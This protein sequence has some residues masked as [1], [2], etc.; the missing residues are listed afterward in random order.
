[1]LFLYEIFLVEYFVNIF[2]SHVAPCDQLLALKGG[3][4]V[5]KIPKLAQ[6][7]TFLDPFDLVMTGKLVYFLF[8]Y[9]IRIVDCLFNIFIFYPGPC[10]HFLDPFRGSCYVKMINIHTSCLQ[11][12]AE[13]PR[14]RWLVSYEIRIIDCLFIVFIYHP[15]RCDQCR[16][17]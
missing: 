16:V 17:V 7:S 9:E 1:M 6:K 11:D 14:H 15:G 2:L 4:G 13:R 3:R 8:S 10:D 12:I 5:K